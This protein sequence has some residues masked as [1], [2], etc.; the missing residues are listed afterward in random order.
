LGR[1]LQR[2]RSRKRLP[3]S[4]NASTSGDIS[5]TGGANRDGDNR[6]T[7]KAPNSSRLGNTPDRSNSPDHN[8]QAHNKQG[9]EAQRK[10]EL[11]PANG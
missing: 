11:R 7:R 4:L 10:R 2:R 3:C 6:H 9:R 5:N 1:C 8:T